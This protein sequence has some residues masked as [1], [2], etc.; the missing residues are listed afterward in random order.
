MKQIL[1]IALI[2]ISC[3]P[4]VRT[5]NI[6]FYDK[7]KNKL[8]KVKQTPHNDKNYIKTTGRSNNFCY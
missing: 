6:Y 4:R 8:V 2:V 1:I 5:E 3:S 7:T